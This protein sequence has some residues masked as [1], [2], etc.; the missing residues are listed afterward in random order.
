MAAVFSWGDVLQIKELGTLRQTFIEHDGELNEKS[1]VREL[2]AVLPAEVSASV[3]GESLSHLFMKIDANSDGTVSWD[4]F[5]SF[6]FLS[7]AEQRNS[8]SSDEDEKKVFRLGTT[9]PNEDFH[10]ETPHHNSA[11]TMLIK[12]DGHP[13]QHER[14]IEKSARS[15]EEKRAVEA[16]GDNGSNG[17]GGNGNGEKGGDSDPESRAAAG[18]DDAEK[19]AAEKDLERKEAQEEHEIT[20]TRGD[21]YLTGGTDG[22]L[23]AWD[24]HTLE[25]HNTIDLNLDWIM[26]AAHLTHT[27]RL[28]VTTA[29]R[30]HVYEV[31]KDRK[32]ILQARKLGTVAPAILNNAAAVSVHYRL[33]PGTQNEW[34]FF[35]GDDGGMTCFIFLDS[36][37]NSKAG[38]SYFDPLNVPAHLNFEDYVD[39]RRINKLHDDH[40][41]QM[42]F[43]EEL[44]CL[45][46]SSLDG[47]LKLTQMNDAG[48]AQKSYSRRRVKYTF[49]GHTKAVRSFAW[50]RSIRMV[51]SCGQ[52]RS[53]K[54]WAP[55]STV[56]AELVG[57]KAS[58]IQVASISGKS[59]LASLDVDSGMRIWDVRTLTCL[60]NIRISEQPTRLPGCRSSMDAIRRMVFDD[61]S[62]VLVTSSH[63]LG[64]WNL[65]PDDEEEMNSRLAAHERVPLSCVLWNHG[66]RQVVTA[67]HDGRIVVWD[68]ETGRRVFW[69]TAYDGDGA[70]GRGRYE[71]WCRW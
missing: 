64:C 42:Y 8:S 46:S 69:F 11:V 34:L 16:G 40:I 17:S 29:S 51:A 14:E 15:E 6:L 49:R 12:V 13:E 5:V 68:A 44:G 27:S 35:G 9:Q 26:D 22:Q 4:E 43:V 19:I 38:H 66:F 31:F 45:L 32:K 1:F 28:V 18:S 36:K 54:V 56:H 39:L 57:H 48:R 67:S 23:L 63:K 37:N 2:R 53:I 55:Y 59:R 58:V 33:E 20:D 41:T 47:T 62:G 7:N 10:H 61:D 25:Y 60:Q 71:K 65:A 3:S 24:S 30:V 52:E 21:L 70:S 50:C